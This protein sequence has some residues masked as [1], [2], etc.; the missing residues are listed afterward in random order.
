MSQRGTIDG[1]DSNGSVLW[2]GGGGG[3]LSTQDGNKDSTFSAVALTIRF[4]KRGKAVLGRNKPSGPFG[5]HGNRS[6]NVKRPPSS[7]KPGR[8]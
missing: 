6:E 1:C 2:A 4:K 3:L 5:D 8:F 7:S